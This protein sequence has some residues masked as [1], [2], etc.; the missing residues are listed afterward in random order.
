M[1]VQFAGGSVAS[2]GFNGNPQILGRHYAFPSERIA[3]G[4]DAQCDAAGP[5]SATTGSA[6]TGSPRT[7]S[8]TTGS[9]T[10]GIATG[11]PTADDRKSGCRQNCEPRMG[12]NAIDSPILSLGGNVCPKFPRGQAS[13][14][15]AGRRQVSSRPGRFFAWT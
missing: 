6:T 4:T 11:S 15:C 9:A 3:C 14:S 5:S 13:G 7:G 1:T 12:G 8:P 2:G 10:T